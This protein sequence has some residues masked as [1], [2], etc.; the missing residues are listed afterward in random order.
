M[1][2]ILNRSI[3]NRIFAIMLIYFGYCFS[4]FSRV[5]FGKLFNTATMSI[6]LSPAS[7]AV[8]LIL[9]ITGVK[10]FD[11]TFYDD[12]VRPKGAV[13]IALVYLWYSTNIFN[14]PFNYNGR[15]FA[16][17]LE[18]TGTIAFIIVFLLFI[19]DM[20]V[21]IGF[22]R[23]KLVAW[24][25]CIFLE[26]FNAFNFI[27]GEYQR[28]VSNKINILDFFIFNKDPVMTQMS[29]VLEKRTVIFIIFL[30]MLY[31]S[32]LFTIKHSFKRYSPAS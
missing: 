3:L 31:I 5:V 2:F 19:I 23:L 4:D 29:W 15:F 25:M 12:I 13:L 22:L 27:F 18:Y 28:L 1:S 20:T 30:Y 32:Y 21:A 24:Y 17:N 8:T 10:L 16:L 6:F 7:L 14:N 11:S 9:L 26:A